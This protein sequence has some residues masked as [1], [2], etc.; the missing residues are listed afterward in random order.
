MKQPWLFGVAYAEMFK[1]HS[2]LLVD[3]LTVFKP[4][5]HG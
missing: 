5:L 4:G 3:D 2:Q 1:A